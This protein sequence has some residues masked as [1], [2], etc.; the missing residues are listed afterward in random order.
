MGGSSMPQPTLLRVE[1]DRDGHDAAR[2]SDKAVALIVKRRRRR[3]G[4]RSADLTG[5]SLQSGLA[6]AA[7]RSDRSAKSRQTNVQRKAAVVDID[8]IRT[9]LTR[10]QAEDAAPPARAR[11]KKWIEV[12][13]AVFSG[14]RAAATRSHP[15]PLAVSGH[16]GS[17]GRREWR[18]PTGS[19]TTGIPA[20]RLGAKPSRPSSGRPLRWP[21]PPR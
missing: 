13:E 6:T 16:P 2:L 3:S 21:V 14:Q 9:Q 7:R 17:S 12:V 15:Q 11:E 1:S 5:H 19:R 8:Q 20:P 4:L 10:R 18:V